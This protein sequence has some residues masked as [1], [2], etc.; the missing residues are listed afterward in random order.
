MEEVERVCQLHPRPSL[1]GGQSGGGGGGGD[2]DG[3][4]HGYSLESH[5]NG[6]ER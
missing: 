5:F 4:A 3:G 1:Y 6:P 2:G